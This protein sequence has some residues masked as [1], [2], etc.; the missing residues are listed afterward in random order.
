MYKLLADVVETLVWIRV[1][2]VT[3]T[4]CV[5]LQPPLGNDPLICVVAAD[6]V[7]PIKKNA[8]ATANSVRILVLR[9]T[10][11]TPSRIAYNSYNRRVEQRDTAEAT[12]GLSRR[13]ERRIC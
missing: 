10:P 4:R 2:P 3:V 7:P 1:G 6:A 8:A 5:E 11:T 13:V 12:P 9:S